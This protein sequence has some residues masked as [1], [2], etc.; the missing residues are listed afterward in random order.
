[1]T[2]CDDV[3]LPCVMIIDDV[4]CDDMYDIRV[5]VGVFDDNMCDIIDEIKI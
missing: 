3:D 1:M 5:L 2:L 4:V